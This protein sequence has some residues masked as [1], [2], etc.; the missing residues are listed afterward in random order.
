MSELKN[1]II[2]LEDDRIE[3]MFKQ[4]DEIHKAIFGNGAIGLKDRVNAHDIC[5]KA[6]IWCIGVIYTAGVTYIIYEY[7]K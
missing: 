5:L 2:K 7:C 4:I 1:R 6:M 3:L